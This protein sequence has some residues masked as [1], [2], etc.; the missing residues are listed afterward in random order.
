MTLATQA[1]FDRHVEAGATDRV[2][3]IARPAAGLPAGLRLSY[4]DNLADVE[5]DWRGFE[6]GADCTAFQTFDWLSTWHRHIGAREG[7]KPAIVIGRQDGDIIFILPLA[8]APG[9]LRRMT[10]FGEFLSNSS[11]PL[12]SRDFAQRFSATKFKVLWREIEQLLRQNLRH[13]LIDLGKIPQTVGAQ[14]N[15]MLALDLTPHRNDAYLVRLTGTWDEFYNAKRSA[16]RRKMDT[17]KRRK[18]EKQGNVRFATA[19]GRAEIEQVLDALMAQKKTAYANLGIANM[20]EWPG[21]RDF[22]MDLATGSPELAHV[23]SVRVDDTIIATS[24][25]L[26]RHGNFDY[27]IPGYLMGE[28]EGSSPGTIHLQELMR[29]F[30]ERGFAT[31]DLNI[32]DEPYKREWYDVETKLYDYVSPV[33]ASGWAA[34]TLMHV[35]RVIKRFLKRTPAVWL[36]IRKARAMLGSLRGSPT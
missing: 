9:R 31:F 11:A 7:V 23:S 24:F 20:F 5:K 25:G 28:Y 12:L 27:V 36:V 1:A 4:H 16:S 15:P 34:A 10:W 6:Q 21:Y 3:V 32:G 33:T 30:M 17:R 18:L 8:L 35:A 29:Y 13:D 14:P 22:F 19:R 2:G 26:T